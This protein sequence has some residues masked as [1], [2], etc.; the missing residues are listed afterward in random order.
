MWG[1]DGNSN[2]AGAKSL[3]SR[4]V[5][6]LI[7]LVRSQSRLKMVISGMVLGSF[8]SIPLTRFAQMS[9]CAAVFS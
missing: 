7:S 8:S 4:W 9:N 2:N 6:L 5:N 1:L 3:V